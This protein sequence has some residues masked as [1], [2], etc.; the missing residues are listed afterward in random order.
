MTKRFCD[1]CDAL[2]EED[3]LRYSINTSE[4]GGS[5]HKYVRMDVCK[6]CFIAGRFADVIKTD[7]EK[8][9]KP[10]LMST[11]GDTCSETVG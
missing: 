10:K 11:P 4:R 5:N 6:D 1:C 8:V 2:I 9:Q 7:L 3:A